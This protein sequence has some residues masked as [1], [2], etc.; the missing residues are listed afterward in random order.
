MTAP[1]PSYRMLYNRLKKEIVSGIYKISDVLPSENELTKVEKIARSTVR[2]ALLQLEKEGYIVKRKGKGSIVAAN[3]RALGVLN[4]Q[5]FSAA[6]NGQVVSTLSV[7]VPK[8]GQWPDDFPFTLSA[9]ELKAGCVSFSRV[10]CLEKDPVMLE[11]SYLPNLNLPRFTRL[12]NPQNS[13]FDFLAQHYHIEITGMEQEIRA[14]ASSSM[15]AKQLKLK[16]G[17]PLVLIHRK[18]Q[19]NRSSLFIYSV[20]H[21][22]TNKYA[23]SNETNSR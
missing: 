1:A 6:M 23:M 11:T 14:V 3:R 12:Y 18:Y 10:R 19:T 9:V 21:C 16:K 5:G 2:Q 8:V 7:Q 20:L 17:D 22:N 13:F 15:A 4:Y